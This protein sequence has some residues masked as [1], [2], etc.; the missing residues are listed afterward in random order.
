MPLWYGE[1]HHYPWPQR[2]DVYTR[3]TETKTLDE[4][5]AEAGMPFQELAHRLH[6]HRLDILAVLPLPVVEET[7]GPARRPIDAT[8]PGF[9][10]IVEYEGEALTVSE[11]ADRYC[12]SKRALGARLRAGW[13][14][15]RTLTE[16]VMPGRRP[17]K[18]TPSRG[19]GSELS[20]GLGDRR[21]I[22]RS[23]SDE[24]GVFPT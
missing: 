20:E 8:R 14:M 10:T 5:A 18:V 12:V 6:L 21:G 11:W 15:R 24:I 19:G 7:P 13:A 2:T 23:I 1:D 4:W 9:G 17:S 3:G 22:I 16:P